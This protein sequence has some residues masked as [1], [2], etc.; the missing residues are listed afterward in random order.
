MPEGDAAFAEVAGLAVEAGAQGAQCPYRGIRVAGVYDA[1]IGSTSDIVAL[2]SASPRPRHGRSL[3]TTVRSTCLSR[4]QPGRHF[5]AAAGSS[6]DLRKEAM[7]PTPNAAPVPQPRRDH[8]RDALIASIALLSRRRACEIPA[9]YIDD[10]VALNWLEWHGGSL[11][12]T[13]VGENICRQIT[14]RSGVPA[15]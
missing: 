2:A 14:Q 7:N 1:S 6:I 15:D 5:R 3:V 8:L 12:V 9:G 10:Y 4:G 13:V 11:R